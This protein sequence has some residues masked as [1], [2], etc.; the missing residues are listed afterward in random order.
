[1]LDQSP[2]AVVLTQAPP[3][4]PTGGDKD[5]NGDHN[6]NDQTL[7]T[8]YAVNISD[9]NNFR[10]KPQVFV[11]RRTKYPTPSLVL[12]ETFC[13]KPLTRPDGTVPTQHQPTSYLNFFEQEASAERMGGGRG[14]GGTKMGAFGGRRWGRRGTLRGDEEEDMWWKLASG[15][16]RSA[17]TGGGATDHYGSNAHKMF[18]PLLLPVPSGELGF[19][20]A[21]E[22]KYAQAQEIMLQERIREETRRLYEIGLMAGDS[23]TM[24]QLR[25]CADLEILDQAVQKM[26]ESGDANG[27]M[28]VLHKGFSDLRASFRDPKRGELVPIVGGSSE[29]ER[30]LTGE[31]RPSEASARI[32]DS[33]DEVRELTHSTDEVP[34]LR[35]LKTTICRSAL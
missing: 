34:L 6:R 3:R 19:S 27:A 16:G 8:N 9:D 14:S 11:T 18:P 2:A 21:G 24:L 22:N 33:T 25:A 7:Q 31:K 29:E 28:R 17:G 30:R 35:G 15:A 20:I 4:P 13:G 12:P 1:M 23:R 26:K 10:L 5:H 32:D